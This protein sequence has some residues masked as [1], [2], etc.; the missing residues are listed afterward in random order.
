MNHIGINILSRLQIK[1]IDIIAKK[2]ITIIE[3]GTTHQSMYSFEKPKILT[4]KI[5]RNITLIMHIRF[6]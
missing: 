3:L 4:Q 5:N 6:I 2:R 1:E